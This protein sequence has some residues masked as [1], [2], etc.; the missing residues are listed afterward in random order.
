[1]ITSS[2]R[3]FA[4]MTPKVTSKKTKQRRFLMPGIPTHK[5][6]ARQARD[7]FQNHVTPFFYSY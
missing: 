2:I 3:S 7:P 4:S 1:M 5:L 6:T